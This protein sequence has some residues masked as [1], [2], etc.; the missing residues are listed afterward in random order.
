MVTRAF[1][2][3]LLGLSLLAFLVYALA[4]PDF[5]LRPVLHRLAYTGDYEPLPVARHFGDYIVYAADA[6]PATLRQR[7]LIVIVIGG[8]FLIRSMASY[9]G[10]ANLLYDTVR[11]THDVA[12]VGYPVRFASTIREAMLSLN[13]N[14]SAIGI[15]YKACHFVGFSAGA[16]L[17]ATFLRKER[18]ARLSE[19]IQVPRIGLRVDSMVSVCGLLRS[20]FENGALDALFR[21][22]IMRGTPNSKNYHA[23]AL[24]VPTLIVSST[25]DILYYQAVEYAQSEPCETMIFRERLTHN[26]AQ[27][28]NLKVAQDTVKRVAKFTTESTRDA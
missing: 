7:D 19:T 14:L 11:A 13:E 17:A 1:V 18:D 10:F 3:L 20:T 9:Y 26:F 27:L 5:F 15:P 4:R 25:S 28:T 6:S 23:R 22:Y 2:S 21:F 24:N 8:A 12:V 16:L